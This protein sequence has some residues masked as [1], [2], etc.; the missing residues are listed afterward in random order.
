MTT[1]KLSEYAIDML[2]GRTIHS[3]SD[4]WIKLD[5]GLVIYLDDSEIEHIND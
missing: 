4:N 3:A 1:A 5:N 2:V